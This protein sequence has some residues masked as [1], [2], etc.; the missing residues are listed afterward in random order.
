MFQRIAVVGLP[1]LLVIS[2][3][4][5]LAPATENPVTEV[6]QQSDP[7]PSW[8]DGPNKKSILEFVR[9]VTDK[10]SPDYVAPA[11][12]IATFDNDGTL[13]VEQPLYTQVVFALDRV[14]ELAVDHPEW[15][16]Q[17]PFRSV[18]Q[19]DVKAMEKFSKKELL[20]IVA[21]THTGMTTDEF[22]EISKGWLAKAKHPRFKKI[23]PK[24]IY[25]PM[26]EVLQFLRSNGFKTYIVSGGG[27]DF[28]R[29]FS[30][31]SYG[32]P[33]EQVIG[34]ALKTKYTYQKK[35]PVIQRIAQL[36]LL[37]DEEGKP[38][39]IELFIGRKPLIA[40]G[41]SDGDRQMLEWT[42][43]GPGL[44]L[45][46]LVHHDDAERE[47]AYGNDSKIGRFSNE[48]MNQAKTQGWSVVSMKNDWRQVFAFEQ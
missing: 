30:T 17:E 47:Y 26:V 45:A 8:K 48:L 21:A 2:T 12:R 34:S 11:H 14:K 38:E 13:W 16:K 36:L 25:Q 37:D 4:L 23:Y 35:R 9:K 39:N 40:F 28:I 27:Q 22:R 32:I 19:N 7:L 10:K 41:N 20:Q 6:K 42:K 46:L 15:Q 31:G 5:A 33:P 43:S 3:V 29:A 24:C 18:I 44:R 1:V